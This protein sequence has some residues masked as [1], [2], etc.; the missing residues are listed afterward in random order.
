MK[1]L[2]RYN[3]VL[4]LIIV[5][6]FTI[7]SVITQSY[8]NIPRSYFIYESFLIIP[9]AYW[10]GPI[11]G[12]ISLFIF[13]NLDLINHVG[14]LYFHNFFD[15]LTNLRFF[16]THAYFNY[17]LIFQFFLICLSA[18]FYILIRDVAEQKLKFLS[19]VCL[20]LSLM[21]LSVDRYLIKYQGFEEMLAKN[22]ITSTSLKNFS[23]S[24]LYSFYIDYQELSS[25]KVLQT[26]NKY[27][28]AENI[29]YDDILLKNEYEDDNESNI[30]L[31]IVESL[32][33]SLDEKVHSF[34]VNDLKNDNLN[35]KYDI[36]F[37]NLDAATGSTVTAEFREL[38]GVKFNDYSSDIVGL[39]C[40]PSILK[41]KGY[42]VYAAHPY[43]NGYFNRREWWR[44]IGFSNTFFM[45]GIN[46]DSLPKCSGAYKSLCDDI[47]FK[48]V[49]NNV[50]EQR[51]PF[52]LYYLSIEGHLPTKIHSEKDYLECF[53]QMKTNRAICGNLISNKKFLK[54][55]FS[56]LEESNITNTNVYIVGDHVPKSFLLKSKNIYRDNQVQVIT[57]KSKL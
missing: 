28:K 24:L 7:L 12:A 13:L 29:F 3:L 10:I 22:N 18:S 50:S 41:S 46:K 53:N 57:L 45:T 49:F 8:L 34:L 15:I 33:F 36:K 56:T 23:N 19:F 21:T 52:F 5:F 40:V 30:I 48:H 20:A 17:Y 43:L 11:M 39:N 55:V 1:H 37:K 51:S 38:C 32:G 25:I 4:V 14:L 31:I 27:E 2:K 54:S 35:D 26:L 47:F 9:I 42:E 16:R 6:S 44:K